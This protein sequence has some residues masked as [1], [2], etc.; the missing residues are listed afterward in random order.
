MSEQGE[1]GNMSDKMYRILLVDDERHLLI[2]LKDY[3]VSERFDV[4]TATSGEE[5]LAILDQTRPDLIVLDIS[6][7]GMGGLGF[8]RQITGA[9]GKTAYPVLVLTARSMLENFFD[10]VA[11]AGFLTKPCD[12]NKLVRTIRKILAS[13]QKRPARSQ[14]QLF[15]VLLAEDD[16][17]LI[18]GMTAAFSAAGFEVVTVGN[19]PD[20][21][22]KAVTMNPDVVVM[23]E[24]LPR[25][26]GSAVARL[27]DVMTSL[28]GLPVILYDERAN[29][30]KVEGSKSAVARCVKQHLSVNQPGALV[31]AAQVLLH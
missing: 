24:V 11:V 25:L 10:S 14:G 20:V 28:S 30:G 16:P 22:D 26:N 6:M 29:G 27:I 5:A 18:P 19:G 15:T 9:D 21:L 31:A 23:K 2:S 8:L 4:V 13:I 1:R 12:E 17:L 3:L 7:P